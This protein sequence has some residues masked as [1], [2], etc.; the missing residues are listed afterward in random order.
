MTTLPHSFK[1]EYSHTHIKEQVAHLGKE[2]SVWANQVWEDSHTDLLTIPVLRGGIFFF[3]DLVREITSSVEIAPAQT[4]AYE[5]EQNAVMRSEIKV[6]IDDVPAKGRSILL[7]DDICDS[8]KT[9]AALSESMRE[10]GAVEVKSAVLIRRSIED[11]AFTPDWVG[12]EYVGP[13]W[14]VGYGMED[15]GRWR[16]LPDI[17]IIQQ[18]K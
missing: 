9:L 8:G 16:N 1:L 13:E 7:I 11:Q 17:Y 2:I 4:W 3:A 18:S 12:F 14:F 5:L 6:R 15:S 10:A